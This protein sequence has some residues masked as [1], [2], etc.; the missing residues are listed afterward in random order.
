M[1]ETSPNTTNY[2]NL[3]PYAGT[4]GSSKVSTA[5]DVFHSVKRYVDACE[6]KNSDG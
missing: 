6:G 2:P 3:N 5:V 1:A 4:N